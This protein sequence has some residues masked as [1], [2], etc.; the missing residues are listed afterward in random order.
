MEGRK[1][2]RKEGSD[3]GKEG[4]RDAFEF[5]FM[6]MEFQ[7]LLMNCVAANIMKVLH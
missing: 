3:E 2:I 7:W 6:K 1:K 4:K 5:I